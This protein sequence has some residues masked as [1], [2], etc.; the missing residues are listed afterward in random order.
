M[1]TVGTS[2]VAECAN[3]YGDL[4]DEVNWLL[5]KKKYLST[6]HRIPNAGSID[7]FAAGR[8]LA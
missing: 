5:K 8:D 6:F 1:E 7:D 4:Q 3:Q 2:V